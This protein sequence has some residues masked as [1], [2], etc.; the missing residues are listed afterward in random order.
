MATRVAIAVGGRLRTGLG[1]RPAGG[2]PPAAYPH[3]RARP[4]SRGSLSPAVHVHSPLMTPSPGGARAAPRPVQ[5]PISLHARPSRAG[6][7]P[8]NK[9][10]PGEPLPPGRRVRFKITT[11][12][13][14]GVTLGRL[15]AQEAITDS[16]GKA[17]VRYLPPKP[18]R[19]GWGRKVTVTVALSSPL[20]FN[21]IRIT[22]MTPEVPSSAA[23]QAPPG[24][25]GRRTVRVPY[26]KDGGLAGWLKVPVG[27]DGK[28]R[29]GTAPPQQR[30]P[31]P[32]RPR[33][34]ARRKPGGTW[35]GGPWR[36]RA[37]CWPASCGPACPACGRAPLP[38]DVF[39]TVCGA[40][41]GG[42]S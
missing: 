39:C 11:V 31:W 9:P 28:P 2:I 35:A 5:R 12:D 16:S 30:S 29:T 13:Q 33:P 32:L 26:F 25:G 7:I 42:E 23:S 21:K 24:T 40:R 8:K 17:R 22:L 3:L 34:A 14:N 6:G 4:A 20:G 1:P 19:I 18:E 41:L 37:S 38:G 15:S 27:P 36:R 10:G